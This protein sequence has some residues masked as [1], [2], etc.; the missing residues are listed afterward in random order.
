[1]ILVIIIL[2]TI[3]VVS[4][5]FS[6]SKEKPNQNPHAFRHIDEYE[7]ISITSYGQLSELIRTTPQT[8][9]FIQTR[10]SSGFW[11]NNDRLTL[12]PEPLI[13]GCGMQFYP[14]QNAKGS[15]PTTLIREN[16][17]CYA[18]TWKATDFCFYRLKTA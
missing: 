13:F 2:T 3:G 14:V 8:H 12:H 5:L 1:M 15:R 16:A 18:G 11:A 7:R 9:Y 10:N 6:L 4:V 17:E